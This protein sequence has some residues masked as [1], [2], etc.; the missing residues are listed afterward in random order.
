M[1][2]T[3]EIGDISPDRTSCSSPSSA[4]PSPVRETSD[5]QNSLSTKTSNL[6]ISSAV[7]KVV[8]Y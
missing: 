5:G 3:T 1:P 7:S 8:K 6:Q 4:S 2:S